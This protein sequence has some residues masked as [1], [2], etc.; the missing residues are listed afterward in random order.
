MT[1]QAGQ[2][3]ANSK[4]T[5]GLLRAALL[6]FYAVLALASILAVHKATLAFGSDHSTTFKTLLKSVA[7]A[8][9]LIGILHPLM[10]RTILGKGILTPLGRRVAQIFSTSPD[11]IADALSFPWQ[12]TLSAGV[13]IF[14]LDFVRDLLGK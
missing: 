2:N 9:S 13:A 4:P 12:I 10:R 6:G 8:A 11:E 1:N 3:N 14:A 5:G 7:V